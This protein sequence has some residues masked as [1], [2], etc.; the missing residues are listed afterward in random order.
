VICDVV[1][2]DPYDIVWSESFPEKIQFYV[3][4]MQILALLIDPKNLLKQTHL[5]LI[6]TPSDMKLL[7][8]VVVL[9]ITIL[10]RRE[11]LL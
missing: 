1:Q 2:F 8:L 10:K 9:I 5:K 7:T 4:D 6:N 3:D 11:V